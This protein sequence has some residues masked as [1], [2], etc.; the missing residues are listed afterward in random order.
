MLVNGTTKIYSDSEFIGVTRFN[1]YY[2]VGDKLRIRVVLIPNPNGQTY[3]VIPNYATMIKESGIYVW[4]DIL[5]QGY[6]E[7]LTGVGVDYP[8]INGRR[9]VYNQIILSIEPNLSTESFETHAN[10]IKVFS[11]ISYLNNSTTSNNN[12]LTDLDNIGKPC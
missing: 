3:G 9:Y 10:T 7:P 11:E 1:K 2:E 8:F 6:V 12:P 4:R 5:S